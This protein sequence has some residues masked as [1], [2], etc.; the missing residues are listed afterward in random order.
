MSAA[1]Q[2]PNAAPS[3]V[4]QDTVPTDANVGW[5]DL[6]SSN[7]DKFRVKAV[8]YDMSKKPDG[9]AHVVDANGPHF[10]N[11]SV[12]WTAGSSGAPSDDVRNKTAI[13]WYKLDKA[14]WYSIYTWQL[15][16]NCNDSYNYYFT[17]GTG[18]TYNLNVF[19]TSTTHEV[20]FNSSDP[21]IISISGS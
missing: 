9:E 4:K 12:Y 7:G 6:V 10:E 15:T 1:I 20:E 16:I 14:P 2:A 21:T 5:V 11:V 18:D 13:T 8:D 17:D 19:F 3:T